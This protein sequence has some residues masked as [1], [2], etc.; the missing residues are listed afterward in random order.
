MVYIKEN[1]NTDEFNNLTYESTIDD[2]MAQSSGS[3]DSEDEEMECGQ[4]V[5]NGHEQ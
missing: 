2:I 5:E 1:E 3:E 4:E